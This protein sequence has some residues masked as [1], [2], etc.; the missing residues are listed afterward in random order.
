VECALHEFKHLSNRQIAKMCDVSHPFVE[1]IRSPGK[2]TTP[3]RIGADGKAGG[4][5]GNVTIP[6]DSEDFDFDR[7]KEQLRVAFRQLFKLCPTDRRAELLTM[8]AALLQE[9]GDE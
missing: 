9:A 2:V 6:P 3:T 8:A 4:V 1:E 5:A 7:A